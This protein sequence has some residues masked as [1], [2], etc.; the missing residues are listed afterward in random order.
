MPPVVNP[1]V[2]LAAQQ[3]SNLYNAAVLGQTM[4]QVP[5]W[6]YGNNTA[7]ILNAAAY[8]TSAYPSMLA[9]YSTAGSLTTSPY[10]SDAGTLTTT[11][12]YGGYGGTSIGGNY[13]M[14]PTY[15]FLSGTADVLRAE[16]DFL[17]GRAVGSAHPDAGGRIAPRLPPQADR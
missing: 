2:A 10:G 7:P 3:Y 11:P 12:N 5:P 13:Y 6:V 4:R 14:D 16:S 8:G 17:K 1:N 9:S 15:G